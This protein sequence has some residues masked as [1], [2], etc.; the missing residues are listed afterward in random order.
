MTRVYGV[1]SFVFR[2]C[3][4]SRA[5]R[6]CGTVPATGPRRSAELSS[7]LVKSAGMVAR[8][9][10]NGL[11]NVNPHRRGLTLHNRG[12]WLLAPVPRPAR[13]DRTSSGKTQKLLPDPWV[14]K[15]GERGTRTFPPGREISAGRPPRNKDISVFFLDR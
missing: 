7:C 8:R 5:V 9:V 14:P 4:W 15:A 13:S 6:R 11:V 1:E 3:A 2:N 12:L 10:W